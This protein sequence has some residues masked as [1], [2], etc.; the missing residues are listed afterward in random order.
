MG[1]REKKTG[2]DVASETN[3][4]RHTG[5]V[6]STG[7]SYESPSTVAVAGSIVLLLAFEK[8]MLQA[9]L[10]AMPTPTRVE[11]N[12]ELPLRLNKIIQ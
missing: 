1:K 4:K 11:T 5:K 10:V 8:K 7:N 2:Q 3:K 12:P 6:G 9:R